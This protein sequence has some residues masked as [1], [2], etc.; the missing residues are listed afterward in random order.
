[1]KRASWFWIWLIA[2]IGIL[3]MGSLLMGMG[4][5]SRSSSLSDL[6][7]GSALIGQIVPAITYM[8]YWCIR[9]FKTPIADRRSAFRL[10]PMTLLVILISNL[11]AFYIVYAAPLYASQKHPFAGSGNFG[12]LLPII[13][14]ILIS[15]FALLVTPFLGWIM[16]AIGKRQKGESAN[17]ATPDDILDQ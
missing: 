1:M 8:I 12:G 5:G 4:P 9:W 13:S 7:F 16:H 17:Q 10:I 14:V 6:I 3:P 2:T 11:I 15:A